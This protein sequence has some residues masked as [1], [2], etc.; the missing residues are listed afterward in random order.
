MSSN[1]AV[2][3]SRIGSENWLTLRR[4][5]SSV[6]LILSCLSTGARSI[7]TLD[8]A[9]NRILLSEN[10][11]SI[12]SVPNSG[13]SHFCSAARLSPSY[14]RLCRSLHPLLRVHF[15]LTAVVGLGW[16]APIC[17]AFYKVLHGSSLSAERKDLG[18]PSDMRDHRRLGFHLK[19]VEVR[20][21]LRLSTRL[22]AHAKKLVCLDALNL[23]FCVVLCHGRMG[24][25]SSDNALQ[26]RHQVDDG[27]THE[28]VHLHYPK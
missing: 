19:G 20:E 2:D 25:R 6:L 7:P 27:C 21:N 26:G 23:K 14:L 28:C 13:P 22:C 3:S 16:A 12:I 11:D 15:Q 24:V 5:F 9:L 17:P 8:L 10:A 4:C 1:N 18:I